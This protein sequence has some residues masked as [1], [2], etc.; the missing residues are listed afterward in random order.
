MYVCMYGYV[1]VPY[2]DLEIRGSPVIQ[3]LGKGAGGGGRS[4]K[5]FCQPFRPRFGLKIRRGL[6]GPLPWIRHCVTLSDLL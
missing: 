4:P 3:T 6:P 2:P 1:T 5:S